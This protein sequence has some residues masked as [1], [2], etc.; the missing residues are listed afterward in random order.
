MAG[1]TTLGE[2]YRGRLQGY[3]ERR[4]G[5]AYRLVPST[6][7]RKSLLAELTEALRYMS[8]SER[9]TAEELFALI[10]KRDDL[11]Y[12]EALQWRLKWWMFVHLGLTYPLLMV[13]GLHASLAHVFYGGL[14]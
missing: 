13:A 6:K 14:P 1:A 9:Q 11:D 4:R 5:W 12:H 3:F 8:D 2:F 10:R 7:L